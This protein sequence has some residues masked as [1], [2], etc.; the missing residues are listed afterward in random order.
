M[1]HG[2][3]STPVPLLQRLLSNSDTPGGYWYSVAR[4]HEDSLLKLGYL[5]NCEFR[6]TNQVIS[7][8]FSSNFFWLIQRRL[9][10]NAD[11]VDVTLP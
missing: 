4:H 10:T 2:A 8:E 5:T 7:S 3:K 9:G 1:Q 6:L 11:Q